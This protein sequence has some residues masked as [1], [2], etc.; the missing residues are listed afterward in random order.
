M[1]NRK[2]KPIEETTRINY[3]GVP[4]DITITWNYFDSTDHIEVQTLDDH[5]IPLTPTGYRSHFCHFPDNFNMD[6]AIEWF[7]Q[8]NGKK[9]SNGF[10]DDFFSSVSHEPHAT[11]SIKQD[12]TIKNIKTFNSE[13]LIKPGAKAN[14]PSLF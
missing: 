10:Q 3:R 4:V 11:Q 5:P 1:L 6:Q 12:E 8:E 2:T 9:D 14:Q 13:P 7:Y